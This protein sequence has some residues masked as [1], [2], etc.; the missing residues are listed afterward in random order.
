MITAISFSQ[1]F[2]ETKYVMPREIYVNLDP[3]QQYYLRIDDV[4]LAHSSVGKHI[5]I[6][7]AIKTGREKSEWI[8]E[9]VE[10]ARV[11]GFETLSFFCSEKNRIMINKAKKWPVKM[12]E[13]HEN[14]YIDGSA[15]LEYE[16]VL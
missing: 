6:D 3:W 13:R 12:I 15:A 11:L 14:Y 5:T 2:F 1:F 4:Y 9:F 7:I 8:N 16:G 10:R